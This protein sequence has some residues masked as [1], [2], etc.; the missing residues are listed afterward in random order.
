[1]ATEFERKFYA[2]G[3][4]EFLNVIFLFNPVEAK[5]LHEKIS[6][7][8]TSVSSFFFLPGSFFLSIRGYI[9]ESSYYK[10]FEK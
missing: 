9:K 7:V 2:G 4:G 10:P 8:I 6:Q 3:Y 1:M 5:Q